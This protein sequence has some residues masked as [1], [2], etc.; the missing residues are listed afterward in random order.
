MKYVNKSFLAALP[1][2]AAAPRTATRLR[3]PWT[4]DHIAALLKT[5]ITNKSLISHLLYALWNVSQT[6]AYTFLQEQYLWSRV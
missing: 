3:K 2:A 5:L 1:D 4:N 6:V